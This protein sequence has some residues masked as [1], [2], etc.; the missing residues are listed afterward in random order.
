MFHYDLQ[1]ILEL[2]LVMIISLS[3]HELAHARTALAFG[4]PTAKMMGRVTLNPLAHL[5]PLGS[6]LFMMAGG[7]GWAKP[8]PVNPANLHPQRL[9]D[10]LVS[11]AGPMANLAL[12]ILGALLLRLVFHLP[13]WAEDHKWLQ[14]LSV[15]VTDHTNITHF[16]AML[17]WWN[18]CLMLFNMIPLFPLDGHHLQRDMLPARLQDPYMRWQLAYGRYVL[19]GLMTLSWFGNRVDPNMPNPIRSLISL[20]G[21]P[22]NEFLIYR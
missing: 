12:A 8:V 9:G 17:V 7:L 14:S 20:V 1:Q 5:D 19:I 16:L 21:N 4:D 11:L 18:L 2:G 22:I 13:D 3:F 6:L 10:F 15:F